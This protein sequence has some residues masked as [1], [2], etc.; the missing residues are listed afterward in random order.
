M[1]RKSLWAAIALLVVLSMIISAC[2]GAATPAP[3]K[4]AA[5][6]APAQAVTGTRDADKSGEAR[7]GALSRGGRAVLENLPA[8]LAG[9]Q[10]LLL[11][12]EDVAFR[13]AA[14]GFS[15]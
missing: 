2:G 4:P 5:S 3:A 14:G 9:P 8:D 1:S 10:R 11:R 6:P 12:P 15:S 13:A 7:G